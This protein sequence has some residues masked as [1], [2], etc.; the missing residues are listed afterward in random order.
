MDKSQY[1]GF[2]RLMLGLPCAPDKP[3]LGF[4]MDSKSVC[5]KGICTSVF[6]RDLKFWNQLACP[7]TVG[8]RM[9]TWHIDPTECFS[10]IKKD[11]LMLPDSRSSEV[12]QF[13]KTLSWAIK[14][15]N[16]TVGGRFF[17]WSSRGASF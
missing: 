14:T 7:L 17:P 11:K 9:N 10:A 2:S 1:K 12:P 13:K 15:V 16:T 5:H 3:L 6:I 4:Y 8:H